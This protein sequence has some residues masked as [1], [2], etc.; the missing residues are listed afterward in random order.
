MNNYI[1]TFEYRVMVTAF[2]ILA[3]FYLNNFYG[4]MG[5]ES[6]SHLN[7]SHFQNLIIPGKVW[8]DFGIHP[9][10]RHPHSIHSNHFTTS[11]Q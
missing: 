1:V 2:A 11:V 9:K 8:V 3:M 4:Q 7:S 6:N 5:F 10:P